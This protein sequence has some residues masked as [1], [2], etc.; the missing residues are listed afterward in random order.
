[1]SSSPITVKA[2]RKQVEW[3]ADH[4]GAGH[5]AIYGNARPDGGL[6]QSGEGRVKFGSAISNTPYDKV[7]NPRG[8]QDDPPDDESKVVIR[9]HGDGPEDPNDIHFAHGE[10]FQL[11][12]M[13]G[14]EI[15]T[16]RKDAVDVAELWN[17]G[18]VGGRQEMLHA[19]GETVRVLR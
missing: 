12:G 2:L 15:Q 6:N 3:N 4:D 7:T 8:P 11:S 13:P 14:G 18:T 1:M 17:D 5:R 10:Q 16:R 9:P 19:N